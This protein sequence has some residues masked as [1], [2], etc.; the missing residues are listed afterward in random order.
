MVAEVG[1]A[2]L[3]CKLECLICSDISNPSARSKSFSKNDR[4][5]KAARRP[6]RQSPERAD[7]SLLTGQALSHILSPLWRLALLV[8][9]VAG[10]GLACTISPSTA[11]VP[12]EVWRL[13]DDGLT[14]RFAEA[15][16][17]GLRSSRALIL[18]TRSR[19]G[20][21]VLRIPNHVSWDR[22]GSETRVQY[23]VELSSLALGSAQRAQRRM[24]G[25][26][27]EEVRGAGCLVGRGYP[28]ES[29]VVFRRTVKAAASP[30]DRAA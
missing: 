27:I 28:Q 8:V 11:P 17:A 21:A 24:Y 25:K 16:E 19:P 6:I 29:A 26:R 18:A 13:G 3:S 2:H 7:F 22:V 1:E 15:I 9:A 12:I 10:F 30:G 23:T 20:A 14:L 4:I 5:L